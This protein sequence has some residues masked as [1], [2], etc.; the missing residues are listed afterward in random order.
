MVGSTS[1]SSLGPLVLRLGLAAICLYHGGDKVSRP[2]TDWGANWQYTGPIPMLGGIKPPPPPAGEW[3]K[4]QLHGP[5]GD[6]PPYAQRT[7]AWGEVVAGVLLLF[8]LLTRVGA[9]VA[10]LMIV[11]EGIYTPRW[12]IDLDKG[13]P[14][15]D[16]GFN[17][18]GGYEYA[19]AL[20]VM[21]AAVFLMG[22]GGLAIDRLFCRRTSPQAVPP[23]PAR[24][25]K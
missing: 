13:F 23:A 1:R 5:G 21:C 9:L 10:A 24:P 17:Y 2:G 22:G 4:Q 20:F 16:R 12:H 11:A 3:I 19:C 8:G 15:L 14:L 6:L 7:L 25:V 18:T